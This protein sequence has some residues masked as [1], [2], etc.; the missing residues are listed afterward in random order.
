MNPAATS[1]V[2]PA[3]TLIELLVMIVIVL[4]LFMTALPT[5]R[6]VKVRAKQVQCA[7]NLKQIGLGFW[8]YQGDHGQFSWQVSTNQGGTEELI[9]RG[10]VADHF[11]KLATYLP[12][13][14]V[15]ICPTD[16]ERQA[17]V[18]K[19]LGFSNTNLSYFLALDVITNRADSL[20]AGDHHVAFNKHPVKPG[21]F[22]FTNPAAISWTKT[23]HSNQDAAALGNLL[24]TD[25]HVTTTK[26]EGL[27]DLL[28]AL[29]PPTP[30]LVIP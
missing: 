14:G 30:R 28:K 13:P 27:P 2:R 29:T 6:G 26:S 7:S 20:I 9:P 11:S 10:G 24:F 5:H 4:V 8:M 22:A 17:G 18:T 23:L 19:L 16:K 3:F 15:F 1:N 25:N 21:L 12:A